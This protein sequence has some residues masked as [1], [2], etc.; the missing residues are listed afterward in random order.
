MKLSQCIATKDQ[1]WCLQG[2]LNSV[3]LFYHIVLLDELMFQ[4][5]SP[6]RCGASE[7]Q[8]RDIILSLLLWSFPRLRVSSHCEE[9]QHLLYLHIQFYEQTHKSIPEEQTCP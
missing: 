2:L 1:S 5:L 6:V 7:L 3:H 8:E 4:V 9:Q